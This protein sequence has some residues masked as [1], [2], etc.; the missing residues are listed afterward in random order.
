[1]IAPETTWLEAN[2]AALSAEMAALRARLERHAGLAPAAASE[3]AGGGGV[4]SALDIVSRRFGLSPFERATLLLCAATELDAR[5]AAA[6]ADAQGDPTRPYPTFGLALAALDGP[7]WSAL[8][9]GAPLRRYGLLEVGAG[10]TLATAP[11]RINESILHELVGIETRDAAVAALASPVPA[12]GDLVASQAAAARRVAGWLDSNSGASIL[13]LTGAD[14]AGKRRVIAAAGESL[15]RGVYACSARDLLGP[16]FDAAAFVRAWSREARLRQAVLFVE[17]HDLLDAP[18]RSLLARVLSRLDSPAILASRAAHKYGTLVLP[19]LGVDRPARAEQ[20]ELWQRALPL[21]GEPALLDRLVD[22][23]DLGS[24]GIA[25]AAA[26]ARDAPGDAGRAAWNAAR[27]SAQ[28]D[29]DDVAQSLRGNVAREDLVLPEAQRRQLDDLLAHVRHRTTVYRRWRMSRGS[30]SGEGVSALFFGPSGTGKTLAASLIA[31]ELE[32]DL[33]RVDLSQVVSKYV[34]ETE[35]NLSRVF[36]AAEETGAVLLFDECDALFGKRGEIQMAHDRY[37]NVEV[38]YLLART[39]SY[40]GLA[41]LTTNMRSAI[42]P[43]FLRRL[44]FI[45]PFPFPD[46]EQRVRIW[47]RAFPPAV[48]LGALDFAKLARLHVSGGNIRN[49]ALYAASLA[50]EQRESVGMA[51]LLHAAQAECAK[52]ERAPSSLEIGDWV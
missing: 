25:A 6:C 16:A 8:T 18:E 33:Y 2:Q 37:A 32:L 15:C 3:Q 12:P 43:A 35:K 17:A 4:R 50:A 46:F 24:D 19:A 9:P 44:R 40:R 11:L 38:S 21:A 29:L 28:S 39:E 22:H 20:R 30:N 14:L 26:V 51:H 49:I 23:F 10:A 27:S 47:E 36:D 42:D 52:I 31:S 5:F 13:L 34:G 1:M 48:P 41:I 45:V 7:H